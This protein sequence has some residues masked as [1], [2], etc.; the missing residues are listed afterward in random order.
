MSSI[1]GGIPPSLRT[2][3]TA[4]LVGFPVLWWIRNVILGR[5]RNAQGLPF[6]PGPKP[7]P[8]VGNIRDIVFERECETYMEWSKTYGKA[9]LCL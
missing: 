9:Y 5:S 2:P 8:L 1:I 7:L 4:L 6:A 3:L